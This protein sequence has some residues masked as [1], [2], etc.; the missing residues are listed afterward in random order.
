MK[1]LIPALGLIFSGT[2]LVA[3]S[4]KPTPAKQASGK[5]VSVTGCLQKGDEAGEFSITGADAKLYALSSTTVALAD[6]VNHKVTVKGKTTAADS[7]KQETD[8]HKSDVARLNVTNLKMVST[9]CQ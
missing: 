4:D 8:T 9:S 2:L 7:D 1:L 5:A 6:H 3:Q